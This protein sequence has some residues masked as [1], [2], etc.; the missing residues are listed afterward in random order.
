MAAI[1]FIKIDRNS[2]TTAIHASLVI[3]TINAVRTAY[4]LVKRLEGIMNHNNDGTNFAAM[5]GLCGIP[6]GQG[7][8]VLAAVSGAIKDVDAKALTER[9]G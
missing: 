9:I 2:P 5:E 7:A 1:D 3:Q 8:T 4:D 6:T